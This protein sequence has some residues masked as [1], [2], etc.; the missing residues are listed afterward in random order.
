MRIEVLLIYGIALDEVLFEHEV[1]PA[2]EI[3]A[4][5]GLHAVAHGQDYVEV[6]V[7]CFALNGLPAFILNYCV[8]Y[9]HY[10]TGA[11]YRGADGKFRYD[12]A[13]GDD[14]GESGILAAFLKRYNNDTARANNGHDFRF[15]VEDQVFG[16]FVWDGASPSQGRW[17]IEKVAVV[18][19][20]VTNP[21]VEPQPEPEPEPKPD[22]ELTPDP[23]PTPGTEDPGK[24]P[25][26][27]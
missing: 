17:T 20:K 14:A 2:L 12:Y 24:D 3:D 4:L 27:N 5:L 15:A 9:W 8:F 19:V 18:S 11:V 7:L 10:H 22:P 13:F 16:T 21:L 1:R 26:K 25:D 23:D 6:V